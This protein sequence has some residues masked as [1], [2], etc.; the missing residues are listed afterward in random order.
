MAVSEKD[1]AGGT[2]KPP[3]PR[4]S[5]P[6]ENRVEDNQDLV[7]HYSREHRLARAS[8]AVRELN[9]NAPARRGFVRALAGSKANIFVLVSILVI[10][11]MFVLGSRLGGRNNDSFKLGGNDVILSIK[12]SGSTL[13]L[14]LQKEAPENGE[15]YTGLVDI[16]VSPAQRKPPRGEENP[17]PDITTGR[18]FFTYTRQE[19]YSLSLPFAEGEFIVILQSENERIIRRLKLSA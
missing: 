6:R 2:G 1:K 17:Q 4:E 13:E 11:A 15:V 16:A 9:E 14:S 3:E 19:A 18:I 10:C 12:K 5:K 7:F 8:L